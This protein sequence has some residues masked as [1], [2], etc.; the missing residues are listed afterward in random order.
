[1]P[2]TTPHKFKNCE[3][4]QFVLMVHYEN[5]FFTPIA[6]SVAL[7]KPTYNHV[8]WSGLTLVAELPG[9]RKWVMFQENQIFYTNTS[10]HLQGLHCHYS[11]FI[12]FSEWVFI[13][14]SCDH[15]WHRTANHMVW[16]WSTLFAEL[17]RALR[18]TWWT[19][20]TLIRQFVQVL[21]WVYSDWLL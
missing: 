7:E 6:T 12:E 5:F 17:L 19:V 11:V 2:C 16:S 1:M 21:Y 9:F 8:V 10:L 4:I 13:E 20:Y 18:V 15:C 14:R 3:I